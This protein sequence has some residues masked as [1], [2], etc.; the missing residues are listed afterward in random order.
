MKSPWEDK[1]FSELSLNSI[2]KKFLPGTD[3]EVSFVMKEFGLKEGNCVLD[4]GCGAGRH[5]IEMAK[6]GLNVTGIDI[7]ECMLNE[8]KYRAKKEGVIDKIKFRQD[9]LADIGRILNTDINSYDAAICFC[10][11]GLS[12][13]GG[14]ERDHEFLKVVFDLLKKDGKIAVT[15]FNGLRRYVKSRD[16]NKKF[17]YINGTLHW[18]GPERDGYVLNE[19]QRLYIPSEIKMLFKLAGF[20]NVEILGCKPG[21]FEKQKLKFEDIEMMIIA[22]K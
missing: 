19:V 3:Q 11:S 20:K 13:L 5:A 6:K 21:K 14:M 22:G 17:D 16:K 2:D 15:M 8:A 18:K 1:E 7:S 9:N 4:L 12:V 10:E